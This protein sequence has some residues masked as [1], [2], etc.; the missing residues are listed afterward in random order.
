MKK[1]IIPV[2]L[3]IFT[4]SA[5]SSFA[6]EKKGNHTVSKQVEI[7]D[8]NG[9]KTVTVTTTTDGVSEVM[10]LTGEEANTFVLKH[11]NKSHHVKQNKDIEVSEVNGVTTVTITT[12]GDGE[13][14]VK[15]LVGDDAKEFLAKHEARAH[16]KNMRGAKSVNKSIEV[17]DENR[18]KTVTITNN[19]DGNET[20][21]V[22]TGQDAEDFLKSHHE[23]RGKLHHVRV[24]PMHEG[25]VEIEVEDEN[26]EKTV[27]VTK[28]NNGE[29]TVEI[30]TGEEAEKFLAHHHKM[31]RMHLGEGSVM[32]ME[33][34]NDENGEQTA[35]K[36]FKKNGQVIFVKNNTDVTVV[37]KDGSF[38]EAKVKTF[39]K[40]QGI[41][42]DGLKITASRPGEKNDVIWTECT[43]K[44]TCEK[45]NTALKA[46]NTRIE[47]MDN[48]APENTKSKTL[49]LDNLAFYPNPNKG[50]FTVSFNNEST[51]AIDI[52]VKDLTGKVLYNTKIKGLG[53]VNEQIDI[54]NNSSGIYILTIAQGNKSLSKK[55][56][57]E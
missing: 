43:K 36:I 56:L 39:L 33:L 26:G 47:E 15:V 4:I 38:D 42:T 31:Q 51:K 24:K 37:T 50:K 21:K 16:H 5:S 8:E 29:E 48:Y 30:L 10:V 17:N 23:K 46:G 55:L 9:V 3:A 32:I 18:V 20:V 53:A 22:L 41:D 54:S 7:S 44:T 6:Q 2:C 45:S 13:N 35:T 28:S 19:I 1:I 12:S 57:V 49:T 25:T 52:T 34:E 11:D 27:T 40:E 14:D